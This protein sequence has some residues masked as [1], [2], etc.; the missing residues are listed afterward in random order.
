MDNEELKVSYNMQSKVIDP[1]KRVKEKLVIA[2]EVLANTNVNENLKFNFPFKNYF[3]EKG[4]V[5]YKD[6]EN[7][8]GGG[9]ILIGIN[10]DSQGSMADPYYKMQDALKMYY[11][12]AVFRSNLLGKLQMERDIL[13]WVKKT[14]LLSGRQVKEL[15]KE[16]KRICHGKKV[17]EMRRDVF[18]IIKM[19]LEEKE[20]D[21]RSEAVYC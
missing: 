3:P 5:V 10:G 4:I 12:D 17:N 8:K 13:R 6:V 20:A 11:Q 2:E 9:I 15:R 14:Q 7:P 21:D 1:E 18:Q 19:K 16:M